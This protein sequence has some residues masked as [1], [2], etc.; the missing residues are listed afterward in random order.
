MQE[1]SDAAPGAVS[2]LA[3]SGVQIVLGSYGSTISGTASTEGR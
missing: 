2:A 3:D 1:G